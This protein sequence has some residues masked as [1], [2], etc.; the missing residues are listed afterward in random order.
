LILDIDVEHCRG[1]KLLEQLC[2]DTN[3]PH[4]IPVIIYA[5]RELTAL[6]AAVLQQCSETLT[7]K[8]VHSPERL[9]DEVTLFLHQIEAK[10]SQEQ[11]Q[12]LHK[13][14]D[15]QA[16]LSGK[17][18]L[19]VDDDMRNVFALA[20]ALE[21]K[22]MEV[23]TAYNGQ[24]ALTQLSEHPDIA[25]VLMDIMMPNMDGYEATRKIRAQ[26]QFRKLPIIALTAKAMKGDKAK[27]I[28]AG[29]NDYLAKP[30]NTDKLI[31]LLRV[32]LYP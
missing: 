10:L 23:I 18:L 32:W 25:M 31:S 6:E 5:E 26:S 19:L 11:Q 29:A 30:I 21:N 15:P 7:L 14:H 20:A 8:E 4:D 1:T 22:G 16:I 17:K 2:H 27:C 13:V 28:E 12:I 9:L 24:D 3:L